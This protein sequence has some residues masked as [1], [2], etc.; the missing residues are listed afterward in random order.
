VGLRFELG[1]DLALGEGRMEQVYDRARTLFERAHS[2]G[3][4][5]FLVIDAASWIEQPAGD[6][7]G[8]DVLRTY[9]RNPRLLDEVGWVE[10]PYSYYYPDDE[11]DE[12]EGWPLVRHCLRC[13]VAE[14]RC[15]ELLVAIANHEMGLTPRVAERCYF[16]NTARHTVFHLYDDR[17]LDI[18]AA[19]T[20]PL[21]EVYRPHGAWILAHDRARIEAVFGAR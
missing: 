5:I 6:R 8:F 21:T 3:D 13:R 18:V 12:A 14:V 17:G 19:R 7:P 15:T 9:L 11:I 20:A 16:V 1:A 4:P 2:P 10:L